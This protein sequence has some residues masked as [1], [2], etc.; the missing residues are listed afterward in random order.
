MV[1]NCSKNS[2]GGYTIGQKTSP[3]WY[4]TAPQSDINFYFDAKSTMQ[5]CLMWE[6]N[7]PNGKTM[8]KENRIQ[9]GK[10]LKK[11]G[12]DEFFC[13]DPKKDSQNIERAKE[14]KKIALEKKA[15]YEECLEKENQCIRDWNE[16]YSCESYRTKNSYGCSYPRCRRPSPYLSSCRHLR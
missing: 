16:Y 14:R 2:G 15:K 5:L 11:R 4:S 10:A 13:T 3:A 9:I 7:Y 1:S 12:K 6:E 8:W